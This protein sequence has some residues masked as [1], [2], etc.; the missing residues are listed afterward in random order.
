[1]NKLNF[2]YWP[3]LDTESGYEPQC[4]SVEFSVMFFQLSGIII[5]FMLLW[6]ICPFSDNMLLTNTVL[7]PSEY[8]RPLLHS[9]S[10]GGGGSGG[11]TFRQRMVRRLRTFI[12]FLERSPICHLYA[13]LYVVKSRDIPLASIF[14]TLKTFDQCKLCLLPNFPL[15]KTI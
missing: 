7:W 8:P 15:I 1:M 2:Y 13:R 14:G 5:V 4:L 9:W 6:L 11:L 3:L 12:F 10:D